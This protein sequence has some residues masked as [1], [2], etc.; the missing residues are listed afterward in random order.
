M[1]DKVDTDIEPLAFSKEI[2]LNHSEKDFV[3]E[4]LKKGILI[5]KEGKV[6]I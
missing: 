3:N 6:L 2:F 4:I 5:Y 1:E